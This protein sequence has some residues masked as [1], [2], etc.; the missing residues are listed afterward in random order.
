MAEYAVGGA[1]PIRVYYKGKDY[2]V[3]LSALYF[4]DARAVQKD[5]WQPYIAGSPEFKAKVDT[6][7]DSL[8]KGKLLNPGKVLPTKPLPTFA[9]P[10]ATSPKVSATKKAVR[11]IAASAKVRHASDTPTTT[12]ISQPSKPKKSA[13]S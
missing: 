6:A 10:A 12:P 1:Q 13:K 2:I 3:P 11:P 8:A 9:A 7:V 5:R 4:D